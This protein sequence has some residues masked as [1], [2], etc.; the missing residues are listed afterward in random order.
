MHECVVTWGM[1]TV[2]CKVIHVSEYTR[3]RHSQFLPVDNI[4]SQD[5][6]RL[7]MCDLCTETYQ[8]SVLGTTLHVKKSDGVE[9]LQLEIRL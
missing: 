6:V 8:L 2:D 5:R 9:Y 3:A 1:L 7:I 4:Q